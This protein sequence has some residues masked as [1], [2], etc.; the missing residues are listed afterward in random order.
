M[1]C[2][3]W[4]LAPKHIYRR[5]KLDQA[6][7]RAFSGSMGTISP[8]SKYIEFLLKVIKLL[9]SLLEQIC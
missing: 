3:R 9:L 7:T 1:A 4:V 2:E 5:Q 6:R 8:G